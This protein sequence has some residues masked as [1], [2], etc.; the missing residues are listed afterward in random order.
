MLA[1]MIYTPQL[2]SLRNQGLR[3][4]GDGDTT[5]IADTLERDQT[6]SDR[7]STRLRAHC[8]GATV[9]RTQFSPV[10]DGWPEVV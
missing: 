4:R 9:A 10:D 7:T 6:L 3:Q 1:Q 2:P 5:T 8:S